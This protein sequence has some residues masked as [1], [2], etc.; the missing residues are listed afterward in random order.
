MEQIR[1]LN[2]TTIENRLDRSKSPKNFAAL[3]NP[4]VPQ[5]MYKR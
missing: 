2:K 5:I 1:A 4:Q 3:S